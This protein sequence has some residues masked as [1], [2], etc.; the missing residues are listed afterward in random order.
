MYIKNFSDDG[1]Y[2]MMIGAADMGT[3][4]DTILSQMAAEVLDCDADK[5]S[6]LVQTQTHHLM[7]QVH[8]LHL[9]LTSR[10]WLHKMPL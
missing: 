5:I 2:N 8:M 6:V 10:E 1:T 3:G 9:Q 7:I 4:C